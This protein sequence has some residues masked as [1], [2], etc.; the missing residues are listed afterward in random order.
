MAQSEDAPA[1]KEGEG[2]GSNSVQESV[3]SKEDLAE[4][5]K[6]TYRR[7]KELDDGLNKTKSH[8]AKFFKS[9]DAIN[10]QGTLLIKY[11]ELAGVTFSGSSMQKHIFDLMNEL[12]K[13]VE[14]VVKDA[15]H[16]R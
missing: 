6:R 3:F 8:G 4:L 9:F 16:L 15:R 10:K 11:L 14:E 7:L 13:E 5:I 1:C 12:K 2:D